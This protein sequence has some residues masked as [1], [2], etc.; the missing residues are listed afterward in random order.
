M[1]ERERERGRPASHT[2]APDRAARRRPLLGPLWL[3][4]L[5]ALV[6]G[7]VMGALAPALA[8]SFKPLGDAFVRLIRMVLAPVIFG[9]VLLGIARMGDLREAGRVGLKALLYFEVVSSAAL[10]LGLVAVDVLRPGAGMHVDPRLLAGSSV[11]TYT[12]AA[13]H[14]GF[15]GFLLDIIPTSLVG[16]FTGGNMLQVILLGVLTGAALA[17]LGAR[18]RPL[19]DGLDTVLAALFGIVRMIMALAPLGTFGAIAFTIG[20]YGLGSL[21]SLL[22]LTLEVWAVSILF[23]TLVLGAIARAA[24]FSLLRFLRFIRAEILVTFGTSSSEAV[25]APLMTKLERL[26]CDRTVVGLVMPA[27]YTFNA[28]GTSI[29]LAMSAIFIA[30]ATGTPLGLGGQLAVMAV[31]VLTSTGSPAPA[32]S[33][34]RRRSPRCT[35]SRSPGSCCCSASTGSPTR[36]ARSRTS[37]AT[38]SRPSSS[39][40]PRARSTARR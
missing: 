2:V 19:L 9:T 23:V 28:D 21:L 40:A 25:L 14:V 1:P 3:Q 6:A 18:A 13:R 27:G 39:H 22:A 16:A 34:W 4:V 8:Q 30:E 11:A 24:G 12:A 37:S 36:R 17:P 33:R 5:V 35:A 29:Y 32:S 26:G 10:L 20:R 31:L 38:A 15:T 7:V